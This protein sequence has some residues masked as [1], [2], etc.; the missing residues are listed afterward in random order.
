MIWSDAEQQAMRNI[1][2]S[3]WLTFHMLPPHPRVIAP[4]SAHR[5][6]ALGT[7]YRRPT[8]RSWLGNRRLTGT[9][10]YSP[11]GNIMNKLVVSALLALALATPISACTAT[12]ETAGSPAVT[13]SP[14]ATQCEEDDPCWICS[15]EDDMCGQDPDRDAAWR[16]FVEEDGARKLK[17]DP[18]RPYDIDWMTVTDD[19]PQ[20]MDT[21]DLALVGKD[22]RWYVFRASYAD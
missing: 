2:A 3:V 16:T 18:S 19:Y 14:T 4:H 20:N 10:D 17:V 13:A 8:I 5:S 22:G 9:N 11:K 7:R 15:P 1:Y 21:Y 6:H 12:P